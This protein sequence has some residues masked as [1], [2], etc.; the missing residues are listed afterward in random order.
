[1]ITRSVHG[2]VAAFSQLVHQYQARVRA[3]IGCYLQRADGVD[4]LGQEVFVAAFK[5]IGTYRRESA[6]ST[7]LLGVAR[8]RVLRHM[9]S[10]ML[11]LRLTDTL[12]NHGLTTRLG[13]DEDDM[14]ERERALAALSKCVEDLPTG[15]DGLIREHYFQSASIVDIARRSGK[16]EGTLRMTLLRIRRRLRDCVERR[17]AGE[18]G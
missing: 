17:L 5:D 15:S 8:H 13:E 3:Y 9:R 18:T 1:M 11:K 12:L 14:K 10:E 4:D 2:D 16:A 6:F 7:W